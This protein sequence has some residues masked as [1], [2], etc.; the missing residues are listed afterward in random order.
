M[1]FIL[2]L[3]KTIG[4]KILVDLVILSHD[5]MLFYVIAICIFV[6]EE[7]FPINKS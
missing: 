3:V 6:L 7:S 2:N 4:N 1:Q 5:V